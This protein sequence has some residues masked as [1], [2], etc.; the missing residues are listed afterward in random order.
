MTQGAPKTGANRLVHSLSQGY[1]M[2]W[3]G[4]SISEAFRGTEDGGQLEGL[5]A[6]KAVWEKHYGSKYKAAVMACAHD[7]TTNLL[8]RLLNGE[9]PQA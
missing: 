2:I 9:S 4:D 3:Y 6:I 1:D 7:R 8:W 5:V